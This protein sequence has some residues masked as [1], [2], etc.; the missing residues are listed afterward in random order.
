MS[1]NFN[2]AAIVCFLFIFAINFL[3]NI[4]QPTMSA[5]VTKINAKINPQDGNLQIHI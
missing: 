3:E 2:Y 1:N 5:N 4:Y